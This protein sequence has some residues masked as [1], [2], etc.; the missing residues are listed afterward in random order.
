MTIQ[1]QY[2]AHET[3]RPPAEK[4]AHLSTPE[5]VH[6]F[7]TLLASDHV[8]DAILTHTSRP[9]FETPIP[10]EDHPGTYLTVPDHSV[11]AGIHGERGALSYRGN[12]GH[13]DDPVH[14][15]SQGEGADH[16]AIYETDEF[17]PNC[18]VPIETIMK[19]LVEFLET[20]KRP[21][22]IAWQQAP[23]AARH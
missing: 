13:S 9:R 4:V 2:W 3:D 19:A 23:N 18:E 5:Q 7:V 1:A 22:S 21:V 17:P 6:E 12:D 15:Y 16:P 11:I 20:G 10:D 14:L 8:S